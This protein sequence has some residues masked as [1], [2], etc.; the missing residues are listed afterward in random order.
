MEA[1]L[2]WRKKPVMR[3]LSVAGLLCQEQLQLTFNQ[4]WWQLKGASVLFSYHQTLLK[5]NIL[6]W[7]PGSC[8][9]TVIFPGSHLTHGPSSCAIPSKHNVKINKE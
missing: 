8:Q 1:F 3:Y 5:V 7:A 6:L 4:F 9:G 2:K